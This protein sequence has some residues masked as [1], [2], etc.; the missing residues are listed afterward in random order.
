MLKLARRCV[1]SES[2]QPRRAVFFRFGGPVGGRVCSRAYPRAEERTEG[3]AVPGAC[4][5]AGER[6]KGSAATGVYLVVRERAEG[7]AILRVCRRAVEIAE[8]SSDSGVYTRV[9]AR[10]VGRASRGVHL[11]TGGRT[12]GRVG[13]TIP[14]AGVSLPVSHEQLAKSAELTTTGERTRLIRTLIMH[15]VVP[16]CEGLQDRCDGEKGLGGRP[17]KGRLNWSDRCPATGHPHRRVQCRSAHSVMAR[18]SKGWESAA[19]SHPRRTRRQ[20][21]AHGLGGIL[22]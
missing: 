18:S 8:G 5:G 11:G 9:G 19:G 14:P 21:Q 10:A 6:V 15:A 4:L 3:R 22:V 16:A 13:E 1:N 12:G 7:G 17:R 20:W 2:C